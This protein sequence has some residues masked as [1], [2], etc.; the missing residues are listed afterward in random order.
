MNARKYFTSDSL[1][2]SQDDAPFTPTPL[3]I[4]TPTLAKLFDG[5][6]TDLGFKRITAEEYFGPLASEFANVP[7]PILHAHLELTQHRP[8]PPPRIA[9]LGAAP[10]PEHTRHAIAPFEAGQRI[11]I[12]G[13]RIGTVTC[14]RK[15]RADGT[16]AFGAWMVEARPDGVDSKTGAPCAIE[17]F[18]AT[19]CRE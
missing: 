2:L 12:P 1:D 17:T 14:V 3:N 15:N 11:A 13:N 18:F 8:T 5:A 7:P 6:M 4:K 19:E 16:P 9:T 10:L